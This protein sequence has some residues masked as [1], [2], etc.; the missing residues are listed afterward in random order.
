MTRTAYDYVILAGA[1]SP[2]TVVIKGADRF[3]NW[4]IKAAKGQAGATTQLN[5]DDVGR[6]TADFYL[7]DD[8]DKD[9]WE[10]FKLLIESMTEGPTPTAYQIYH[11]DLASQRF[12]EVAS[13]G[14][15]Q[16]IHDGRGGTMVS[17]KFLEY[18]PA[19]A[20]RSSKAKAKPNSTSG[21]GAIQDV[22]RDPNAAA[23]AQLSALVDEASKP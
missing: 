11:P 23:K 3:K 20:K 17:V 15:G 16:P 10:Y 8:E 9:E 4:D 21:V 2:G 5:G 12:T 1:T 6:F 18:K 22:R 13:G 14:I 7:A 19:K